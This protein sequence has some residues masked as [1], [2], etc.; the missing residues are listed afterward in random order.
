MQSDAV[1][2][3][4]QRTDRPSPDRVEQVYRKSILHHAQVLKRVIAPWNAGEDEI[5]RLQRCIDE[6]ILQL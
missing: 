4:A 2:E 6:F 3:L 1:Q 5:H